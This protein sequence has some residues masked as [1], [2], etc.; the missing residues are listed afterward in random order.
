M[1]LTLAPGEA[2]TLSAQALESGGAGM[3]GSLG[4]GTGKWQ[5]FVSADGALHVMSLLLSPTGHLSN[6][7]ASGKANV[8]TVAPPPTPRIS[9][10]SA[11]E[12]DSLVF[13]VMLDRAPA[14]AVT[15]YYATYQGTARS[16]DCAFR[17]S[18]S[19]IPVSSR[20]PSPVKPITC[21]SEA[22]RVFDYAVQ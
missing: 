10:A 5:L 9:D 19:P 1:S 12:G 4:D 13:T 14:E 16:E 6:L 21:R 11:V 7:S 2:R 8:V 17:R 3:T 15:Y 22:T 18:R 20:S